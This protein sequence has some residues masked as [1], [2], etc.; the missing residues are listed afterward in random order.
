[1]SIILTQ[2]FYEK[3]FFHSKS[4]SSCIWVN[5]HCVIVCD[6]SFE[7]LCVMELPIFRDD[8]SAVFLMLVLFCCGYLICAVHCLISIELA[9]HPSFCYAPAD[10]TVIILFLRHGIITLQALS[11]SNRRLWME[12]MDGKEPV[13]THPL[14]PS[15][16]IQQNRLCLCI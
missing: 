1:M 13:R 8:S 10:E 15:H 11:D 9:A 16:A 12:A 6:V 2:W 4:F 5:G 7:V 14:H 3:N